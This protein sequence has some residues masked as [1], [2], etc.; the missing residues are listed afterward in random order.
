KEGW[1]GLAWALR[2]LGRFDEADDCVQRVQQIDPHDVRGV[3]HV[4]ATGGGQLESCA[5]I[6]DLAAVLDNPDIRSG[7]RAIAGFALGTTLVEQICASHSRVH[8]AGEL[9]SVARLAVALAPHRNDSA[10]LSEAARRTADAHILHLHSLGRGAARVTDK[11]PD[12]I[13]LVGVIARLF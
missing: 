13:L 8:G 4:P 2:L 1:L 9:D 6:D 10:K 7:D 12:N 11:L 5:D 3:A